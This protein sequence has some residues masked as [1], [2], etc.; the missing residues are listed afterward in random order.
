MKALHGITI[1]GVEAWVWVNIYGGNGAPLGRVNGMPVHHLQLR[2]RGTPPPMVAADERGAYLRRDNRNYW[3]PWQTNRWDVALTADQILTVMC[4]RLKST[5]K[6]PY[7]QDTYNRNYD[8][9]RDHRA[10]PNC[11]RIATE[12]GIMDNYITPLVQNDPWNTTVD[13]YERAHTPDPV[14]GM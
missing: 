10:C 9:A 6:Q 7:T 11:V 2:Q 8:N 5:S 3:N 13:R 14:S 1:A 4:G 12:Q